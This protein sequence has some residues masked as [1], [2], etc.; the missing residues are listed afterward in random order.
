M[1]LNLVTANGKR[2]IDFVPK[3]LI[4]VGFSGRDQEM[5]RR[6][7][8][9][10]T[11]MGVHPPDQT[12]AIYNLPPTLLTTAKEVTVQGDRTNGEVEYVV[13]QKDGELYV[14]VGSDHTDRVL[15]REM[16]EKSKLVC[17]KIIAPEIWPYKDVENHWDALQLSSYAQSERGMEAYQEG[18][19]AEIM[20]PQ[21]LI[22]KIG[23]HGDGTAIFSG[24]VP[25]KGEASFPSRFRLVMSDPV[26]R[27]SITHEYVV[28]VTAARGRSP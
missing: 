3:T 28:N 14:T 20:R 7:I 26:L 1:K 13:L 23:A 2:G 22:G 12:P 4:I 27:R 10:L 17:P 21:D 15:E 16:I 8:A 18:G 11:K 19:V 24:T 5:V 9:E 6:H 25:L